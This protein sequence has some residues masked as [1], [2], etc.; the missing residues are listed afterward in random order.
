M[1]KHIND[2]IESIENI[3]NNEQLP[4]ILHLLCLLYNSITGKTIP[5]LHFDSI[6]SVLSTRTLK[7]NTTIA[8]LLCCLLEEQYPN[9]LNIFNNQIFLKLKNLSVIKYIPIYV[10]IRLFY[11]RYK[12]LNNFKD[13]EFCFLPEHIK[14]TLNDLEILFTKLF[15]NE[16]RVKQGEKDLSTYF[17]V[18]DLSLD[19]CLLTLGQFIDKI[20]LAH[21]QNLEQRRRNQF[22]PKQ[23]STRSFRN[24]HN[25]YCSDT[26]IF[27]DHLNVPLTPITA[28]QRYKIN[29][30][31]RERFT[32]SRDVLYD[33]QQEQSTNSI[34]RKRG[35]S[36]TSKTVF[37][38]RPFNLLETVNF[39]FLNSEKNFF[40]INI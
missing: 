4:G 7:Q 14:T 12:Q 1:N 39:I 23:T 20:R 13:E 24:T 35:H 31:S 10:D 22:V 21:M 38:K 18:Y 27:R 5:G 36:P 19:I 16:N 2:L 15:D 8:H 33:E 40:S 32:S 9:L 37:T 30:I 3:L 11:T 28:R 25:P 26:N 6:L 17:C 29:R 34:P